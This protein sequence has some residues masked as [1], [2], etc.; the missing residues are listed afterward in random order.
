M[1]TTAHPGPWCSP[2]DGL[3]K[4]CIDRYHGPGM[5]EMRWAIANLD[6]VL[7]EAAVLQVPIHARF[8]S[9]GQTP[10]K[11]LGKAAS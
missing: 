10:P 3:V 4:D 8:T 1:S 2:H 9:T 11:T 7:K 5:R 6:L